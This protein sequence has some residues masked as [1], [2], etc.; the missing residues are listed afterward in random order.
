[1]QFPTSVIKFRFLYTTENILFFIRVCNI[2]IFW[3]KLLY[4]LE[5]VLF[6]HKLWYLK[7]TY[8]DNEIRYMTSVQFSHSV[9]SDSLWPHGLQ[10]AS[11]P[12][13]SPNPG[14]YSNS[15]P[16]SQ[17]C[18]PTISSSV[19]PFSLHLQ[20]FQHQGLFQWISSSHQV[21]EV[22][23]FQLQHQSFQWIFRIDFL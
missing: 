23:E 17:W 4:L 15:C 18:H 16:L 2:S 19:I 12:C 3:L 11:F 7:E 5:F 22:L 10:H 1:M 6:S 20:S 9:M 8:S 14:A 21:A 13:P